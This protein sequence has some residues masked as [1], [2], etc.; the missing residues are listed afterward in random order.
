MNL[1]NRHTSRCVAILAIVIGLAACEETSGFSDFEEQV[2]AP[3]VDLKAAEDETDAQAVEIGHRLIAAGEYELAIDAFNRAALARGTLDAE[4][5]SGYGTANL[6]LGRLGQAESLL[7]RAIEAE[8]AEPVDYNNLGV[9][10][11]EKG[12]TAE[13]IQI[14][15]TGFA[16]SNGESAA[17]GDNLR[18]ALAKSEKS[19]TTD[20]EESSEFKLVRRGASDYLIRQNP[21]APL[22]Q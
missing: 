14:F 13:A 1:R 7:R 5:L 4:L 20:P 3:G 16:L 19:A 11:M 9:V 10:L 22:E 17:I 2:F 6:G 18:L 8:G 15:K 21:A 12:E